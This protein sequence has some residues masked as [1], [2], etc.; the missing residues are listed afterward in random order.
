M[1]WFEETVEKLKQAKIVSI[2]APPRPYF[3]EDE[4][5]SIIP[6]KSDQ[7]SIGDLVL[8]GTEY[9]GDFYEVKDIIDN[10]ICVRHP[11]GLYWHTVKPPVTILGKIIGRELL[12]SKTM[13]KEAIRDTKLPINSPAIKMLEY[14]PE[15]F[16]TTTESK[17]FWFLYG[18]KVDFNS[19]ILFWLSCYPI[20]L[21]QTDLHD[22][23]ILWGNAICEFISIT[24]FTHIFQNWIS[25][26]KIQADFSRLNSLRKVMLMTEW[27][28]SEFIGETENEYI[29]IFVHKVE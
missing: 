8:V 21:K 10:E 26:L 18:A 3:E 25:D 23:Y 12:F 15:N 7:L 22:D 19:A 16:H 11:R 24:K 20:L 6:Y 14:K 13:L 9:S 29:A 5:L 27:G 2:Q 28:D 4:E 1:S 17:Y